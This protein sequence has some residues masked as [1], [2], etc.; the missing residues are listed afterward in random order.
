MPAKMLEQIFKIVST[1]YQGND[2]GTSQT[3]K[4]KKGNDQTIV[5][6]IIH[7]VPFKSKQK[8]KY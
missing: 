7:I 6:K 4:K 3:K 1:N 2:P 5:P 8:R